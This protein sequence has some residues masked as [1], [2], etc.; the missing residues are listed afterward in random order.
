[1]IKFID[2]NYIAFSTVK[3]LLTHYTVE[4]LLWNGKEKLEFVLKSSAIK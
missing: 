1:M 2:K 3:L 4:S